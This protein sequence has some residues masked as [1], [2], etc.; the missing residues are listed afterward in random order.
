MCVSQIH[1]ASTIK[2]LIKSFIS[3]DV[4]G[5]CDDGDDVAAT[6]L[7]QA[8]SSAV[9]EKV[10]RTLCH[11]KKNIFFQRYPVCM[12]DPEPMNWDSKY[13]EG[14]S[15]V[16]TTEKRTKMFF[17]KLCVETG[18]HRLWLDAECLC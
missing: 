9:R 2:K 1:P 7:V 14:K 12:Q 10:L 11:I 17:E 18:R 8:N 15:I 3:C 16:A 5:E 4:T 13:T 6:Q